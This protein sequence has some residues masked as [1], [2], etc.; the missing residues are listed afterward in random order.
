MQLLIEGVPVGRVAAIAR[1]S[2]DVLLRAYRC[3]TVLRDS[4]ETNGQFGRARL[5]IMAARVRPDGLHASAADVERLLGSAGLD[6]QQA[7][8]LDGEALSDKIVPLVAADPAR[9]PAAAA[10]LRDAFVRQAIRRIGGATV[11]VAD[12]DELPVAQQLMRAAAEDTPF[13]DDTLVEV[14]AHAARR[15]H[16]EEA[17]Q[18]AVLRAAL[19]Q[20]RGGGSA[21]PPRLRARAEG[22]ATEGVVVAGGPAPADGGSEPPQPWTSAARRDVQLQARE[23]ALRAEGLVPMPAP[24]AEAL[25]VGSERVHELARRIVM[26]WPGHGWIVGTLVAR[27]AEPAWSLEGG[28]IN[29][30]AQF[31]CDGGA[32]TELALGLASHG[33]EADYGWAL[34]GPTSP[35][36]QPAAPLPTHAAPHRSTPAAPARLP[37]PSPVSTRPRRST[38]ATT[39]AAIAHSARG[40]ERSVE[41]APVETAPA[42][43]P[44]PRAAS[45]R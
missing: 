13:D 39:D 1:V 25:Q 44:S 19:A 38:R 20:P 2:V 29:V 34:Y 41:T 36:Q 15:A 35:P 40:G 6:H 37:R 42:A 28:A 11:A 27:N 3:H 43:A 8:A 24:A 14:L 31:T 18:L 10:V 45:Q 17:A 32:E 5:Q 16:D 22:G 9:A 21:D 26:R 30:V 4:F 7:G 33:S 23:A 12:D